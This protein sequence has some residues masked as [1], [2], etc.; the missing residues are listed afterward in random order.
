MMILEAIDSNDQDK[1]KQLFFSTMA[2]INKSNSGENNNNNFRPSC[3]RSYE[4]EDTKHSNENN[5]GRES[6]KQL[7]LSVLVPIFENESIYS[8]K[9]LIGFQY[10]LQHRAKLSMESLAYIHYESAV[11]GSTF[12]I[13][14]MVDEHVFSSSS[15]YHYHVDYFLTNIFNLSFPR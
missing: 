3:A 2:H 8:I 9:V 10:Q 11:P 13:I 5:H 7:K 6:T 12:N 14:G 15:L 1:P 4:V